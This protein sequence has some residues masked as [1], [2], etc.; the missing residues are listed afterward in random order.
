MGRRRLRARCRE[1]DLGRAPQRAGPWQQCPFRADEPRDF[2]YGPD[3]L[4]IGQRCCPGLENH[5]PAGGRPLSGA[6]RAVRRPTWRLPALPR[7]HE[8]KLHLSGHLPS[9]GDDPWRMRNP[10]GL[11]GRRLRAAFPAAATR[12]KMAARP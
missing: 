9:G 8:C 3:H 4:L 10:K 5:G 12:A 11:A 6:G 2:V 1:R 7:G